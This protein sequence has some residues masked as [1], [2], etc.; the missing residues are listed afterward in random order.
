LL[1]LVALKIMAT[2]K[3]SVT[4]ETS[5]IERAREVAGARGLSA[6]VNAALED[7]LERDERRR[8]F[9]A[10]LDELEAADPSSEQTMRRAQRRA[11][12]IRDAVSA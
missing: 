5:A 12:K 1:R 4:L 11:T 3:I 7:K 2:R 9:L 6:Y 8:S 10:F